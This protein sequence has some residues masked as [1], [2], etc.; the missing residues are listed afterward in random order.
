MVKVSPSILS[1]DYGNLESELKK[2]GG[3]RRGYDSRR[4]YG[5]AFCPEH[6]ARRADSKVHKKATSLPLTCIL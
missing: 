1:S 2:I 3:M 4:R 6:H 5:R